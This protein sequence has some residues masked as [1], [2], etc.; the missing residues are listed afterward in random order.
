MKKFLPG[1][2]SFFVIL[3]TFSTILTFAQ[4]GYAQMSDQKSWLQSNDPALAKNKR[5]VYDFWREVLEGGHLELAEKYMKESYIQHNPNVPTGRQGFIDFFS[6]FRK[7][8]PIADSIKGPLIAIL[9]ESDRVVLVFKR[10][11]NEPNDP[12][13]KYLTHS[14]EMLRIEDGKVAEHWDSATK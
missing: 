4:S 8:Q 3:L 2:R 5:I 10:E 9:A 14:F 7:P 6:K 11:M 13:K 12:S 1:C